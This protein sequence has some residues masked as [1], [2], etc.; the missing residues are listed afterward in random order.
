VA[1]HR[2]LY[3]LADRLHPG[4]LLG[5]GDLLADAPG[6]LGL[7]AGLAQEKQ[8]AVHVPP[9]QALGGPLDEL[10]GLGGVP[11]ETLGVAYDLLDGGHERLGALVLRLVQEP[12][13]L[14]G[15]RRAS[16]RVVGLERRAGLLEQGRRPGGVHAEPGD[17]VKQDAG[18]LHE[19][20][21]HLAVAHQ[22]EAVGQPDGQ[23]LAGG[24]A[25][26]AAHG[27]ARA[28]PEE[29]LAG[30]VPGLEGVRVGGV[31][32]VPAGGDG[33]V[34]HGLLGAGLPGDHAYLREHGDVASLRAGHD[35]FAVLRDGHVVPDASGVLPAQEHVPVVAVDVV[36]AERDDHLLP[37]AGDAQP[38][39][40]PLGPL[41]RH[42]RA[43]RPDGVDVVVV[44]AGDREVA[45]GHGQGR[46]G[47]AHPEAPVL[48]APAAEGVQ[49]AV[50][51]RRHDH[52]LVRRYAQ[53]RR[54]LG[55]GGAPEGGAGGVH[56]SDLAVAPGGRDEPGPGGEV[57]GA[58]VGRLHP[59]EPDQPAGVLGELPG[60]LEVLVHLGEIALRHGRPGRPEHVI[61]LLEVGTA[62]GGLLDGGPGLGKA[63]AVFAGRH[64]R[65]LQRLPGAFP[66]R[67]AP[68]L[69]EPD[70][71]GQVLL[72]GILGGWRVLPEQG[73][74]VFQGIA[75]VGEAAQDALDYLLAR[76]GAR[77]RQRVQEFRRRRADVGRAVPQRVHQRRQGDLEG[78]DVRLG[79]L[80]EHRDGL[81]PLFRRWAGELLD[82]PF[83]LAGRVVKYHVLRLQSSYP[84]IYIF[85]FES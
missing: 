1:G 37:V 70:E 18:L 66:D 15:R 67:L 22:D 40:G 62:P 82:L 35:G 41:L 34:R 44:A 26:H 74:P 2:L 25:R 71:G 59:P 33:H 68:V 83:H 85:R 12:P 77:F 84:M 9:A 78:L 61:G 51:P 48:L 64:P 31:D 39:A 57:D 28:V 17:V 63:I 42:Q 45:V 43:G 46:G 76:G 72:D 23:V 21:D 73:Q 19:Q 75:V 79:H 36:V 24:V 52:A 27:V 80:G 38:P 4:L 16:L 53:G 54:A 32:A 50:A 14:P 20:A 56:Q 7:L 69:Q 10:L 60:E 81:E 8:D 65:L 13:R 11:A 29:G 49:V 3:R 6:D 30:P 55:D 5:A 47:G 58:H